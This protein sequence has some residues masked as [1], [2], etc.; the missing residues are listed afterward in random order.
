VESQSAILS[1]KPGVPI[2]GDHM[3][4]TKF[5]TKN[6]AGYQKVL[7]KLWLWLDQIQKSEHNQHSDKAEQD[8]APSNRLLTYTTELGSW[9]RISRLTICLERYSSDKP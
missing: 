3:S 7:D 8:S 4:M 1:G 5:P 6:E 9:V 2:H